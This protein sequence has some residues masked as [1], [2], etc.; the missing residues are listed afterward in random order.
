MQLRPL[1]MK[2]RC[3][4]ILPGAVHPG[5]PRQEHPQTMKFS[6]IVAAKRTPVTQNVQRMALL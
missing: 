2:V 5:Q 4:R 3:G 6:K 1:T